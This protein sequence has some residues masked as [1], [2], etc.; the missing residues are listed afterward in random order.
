MSLFT[1]S[2]SYTHTETLKL[3]TLSSKVTL[4]SHF[5][6][7]TQTWYKQAEAKIL[8]SPRIP[9]IILA[10]VEKKVGRL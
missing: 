4:L 9:P 6:Q 3:Q 10:G 1:F 8:P 2:S 5:F 7:V